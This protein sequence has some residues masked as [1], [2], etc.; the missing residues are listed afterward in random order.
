MRILSL[1]SL[2]H[3]FDFVSIFLV[4]NKNDH[5]KVRLHLHVTSVS[6]TAFGLH[7]LHLHAAKPLG[8]GNELMA[9]DE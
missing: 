2:V 6:G 9:D 5:R 3:E 1:V 8:K 7:S 4:W